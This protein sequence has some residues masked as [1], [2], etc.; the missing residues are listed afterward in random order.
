MRHATRLEMAE[1]DRRTIADFGV[2]EAV[3]MERAGGAVAG[4]IRR[5]WPGRPVDVLCGSGKNGGD[6]RVVA[7]LLGGRVIEPGQEWRPAPRAVVVDAL[8]G[9]G[10]SRDVTGAARSLIDAVNAL[11]REEHPVIA[12][13]VPSGL[14]A[15]TGRPR[16]A[17]VR[18]DV[19]VTMGL[20][21]IGF[22]APEA[23]A[24]LGDLV[25]A[26]IGH[27]PDLLRP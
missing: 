8:F 4:E 7:R 10:L 17:A 27:P 5:R 26:D 3:L 18:A 24:Y 15:D 2:P 23:A 6:G 12:V 14:D 13:D 1:I 21:K 20:P 9:T 25:V 16:G 22:L 11:V 19:T